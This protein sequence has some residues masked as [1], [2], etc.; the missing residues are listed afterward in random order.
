M[1]VTVSNL[2]Q[3]E[4]QEEAYQNPES[5]DDLRGSSGE[6]AEALARDDMPAREQHWRV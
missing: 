3:S 2:V 5:R 1:V 4:C 6:P